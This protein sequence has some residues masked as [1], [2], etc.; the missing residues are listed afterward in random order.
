MG[1][2]QGLLNLVR[3]KLSSSASSSAMLNDEQLLHQVSNM[4]DTK[5]VIVYGSKDRIVRFEGAVA[6]KMKQEFPN[7]HLVRMEGLGHDPFEEDVDG[8]LNELKAVC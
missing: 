8:F 3:H 7:L 1:W 5:V 4:K 2:E 6:E